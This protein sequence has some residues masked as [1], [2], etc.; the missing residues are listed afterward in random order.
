MQQ[1]KKEDV[2]IIFKQLTT[3]T[4][5]IVLAF[6]MQTSYNIVDLFWVGKIGP[7]AIAAVSL[8]GTI[9]Y[10]ILAVGQILG[11]GTVAMV[12]HAFGANL[13]D[14]ANSIIKQSLFL[15]SIIALLV[16][17]L[18]IIF[19]KQIMVLLGG[20]GEVL[21]MS[22]VYLRIVFVG[23]FFQLLSFSVNYG[24]RGAGDMKTP[25]LIMLVATIINIVLDPFL[26]LGIGFFPRLEVQGAAIATTIAK[27]ISFLFGFFI[28]I[29]GKSGI[30]LNISERWFLET[31]V[32]RTIL[33]VGI[34]VGISYA[35]MGLSIMSVFRIVASF[36]DYAL[37]ALGV[38]N[39]ILQLAGLIAVSIGISTTTMA[40][41][42]LGARD[43]KR[44]IQIGIISVISS[45][46]LMVLCS[47]IFITHAHSLVSIFN[48]D[49]QVMMYGVEFLKIV[50][51]Y[52]AFT[53]I[54]TSLTGVFRGAGNTLPPMFAGLCKLALL[55]TLA[56]F[57]TQQLEMDVRGVWWA[58]FIS[59]GIEALI[60]TMWYASGRWQKRG[61]ALLDNIR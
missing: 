22:V 7:T 13:I 5:P 38:G 47:G 8:A 16:S 1:N 24:F 42:S 15:A 44:T 34:P 14:R 18:G 31:K 10:V 25:M 26:I 61:L 55:W 11:S 27:C 39:R 23:F 21:M 2:L 57:F 20:R 36:S 50:S 3:L 4:W 12:A 54:T 59:Y 48:Q 33:G 45:V 56:L 52:L 19:T 46:V 29:K 49:P 37:A 35:L 58:M 32:V 28:L 9:F 60:I 6:L 51:L 30:K 41:Q 17:I 40:G 53:S 43:L